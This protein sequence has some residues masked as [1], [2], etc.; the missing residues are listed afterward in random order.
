M[1][2]Q[3]LAVIG[4]FVG[5]TIGHFIREE[6]SKELR[7]RIVA[8]SLTVAAVMM[9]FAILLFVAVSDPMLIIVTTALGAVMPFSF[10][11]S[12]QQEP[13]PLRADEVEKR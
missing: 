2:A 1:I 8:L 4:F 7:R 9:A 5:A 6:P 11:P 12:R 13:L 3:V 10:K